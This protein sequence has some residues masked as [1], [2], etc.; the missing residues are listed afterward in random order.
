MVLDP[1][2]GGHLLWAVPRI[3]GSDRRAKALRRTLPGELGEALLRCLPFRD[4]LLGILVTQ[5][6]EA[7][8]AALDDLEAALDHVLMAAKQPR[9]LLRWLQMA[10][11][12][13]G[14]AIAG[15]S[16]RT[17]FADAGKHILQRASLGLVV[18]NVIGCDERQPGG[19]AESGETNKAPC[20]VAAIEVVDGEI[21]TVPEIGR[22]PGGEICR[23][24]PPP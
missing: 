2:S 11:G 19:L 15:L 10:L 23:I 16:D 1:S 17:A 13:G 21:D 3:R 5:L 12:I 6:V 24:R 9:H 8:P 7:E 20:I 18:E 4:W 14:E 22:Y